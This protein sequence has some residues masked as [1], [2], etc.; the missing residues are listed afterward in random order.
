[1]SITKEALI[2]EALEN[3]RKDRKK[4]EGVRDQIID[5]GNDASLL[6]EPTGII[7]IAEHVSKLA[8][9]LT[10]MNAQLVE[11]SKIAAKSDAEDQSSDKD[12]IFDEI[13]T[14]TEQN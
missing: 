11:M 13:E 9:V 7:A 1:M 8:D 12:S 3:S 5:L 2:N 4:L 6:A 14:P 10:K